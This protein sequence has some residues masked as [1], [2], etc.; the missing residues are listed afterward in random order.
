MTCA[1]TPGVT[2]EPLSQSGYGITRYSL[3]RLGE[4]QG[5]FG[6][7]VKT[8]SHLGSGAATSPVSPSTSSACLLPLP[9]VRPMRQDPVRPRVTAARQAPASNEHLVRTACRRRSR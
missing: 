2:P 5:F 7:V 4:T 8:G 3:L 9:E 1:A 6:Q